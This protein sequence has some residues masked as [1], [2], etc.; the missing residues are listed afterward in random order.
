M[1][2]EAILLVMTVVT[3]MVDAVSFLSLGRVLTANMTGN[4]LLLGFAFAGTSG[5]SIMRSCAALLAF[6]TGALIGGRM[7]FG[8]SGPRT[9][10]AFGSEGVLLLIAA[11]IS[12]GLSESSALYPLIAV[13]GIAMGIRNAVVRKLAVPDLTTTVLTLTITG[14][15]ADSALAGGLNPRWQ[16]RC[17]AVLAMGG[18]ALAGALML[19]Y[20][21]ALPLCVCA[22][23]AGGCSMAMFR[24][25]S[26]GGQ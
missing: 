12:F 6:M 9:A 1:S 13:V 2:T 26:R 7:T 16:R 17:A 24:V 23:T 25:E 14:L 10:R 15:V 21:V 8:E 5:L 20:S 4:I 18:G 19:R 22:I 3:G 11:A